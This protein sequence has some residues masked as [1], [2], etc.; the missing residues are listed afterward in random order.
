LSILYPHARII[1]VD[2]SIH[3]LEKH[4][5]QEGRNYCLVQADLNDFWRLAVN[6]GWALDRHFLLYPN[7]YPKHAHLQRRWYAMSAF[8]DILALGGLLIVRSNWPLYIQE[9]QIALGVAGHEASIGELEHTDLI[10]MTLFEK[11]YLESQ[12]SLWELNCT[13]KGR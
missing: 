2:K 5:H 9:F 7:P 11:K 13:I 6:A 8:S 4:A 10:P 12:Q 1:G 3:R